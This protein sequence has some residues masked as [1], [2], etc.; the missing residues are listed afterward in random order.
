L[1]RQHATS[2]GGWGKIPLKTCGQKSFR[3]LPAL[4]ADMAAGRRED[5]F[6]HLGDRRHRL[7]SRA[8]LCEAQA[9]V[10]HAECQTITAVYDEV[11]RVG[12]G[13]GWGKLLVVDTQHHPFLCLAI[14]KV[15]VSSKRNGIWA[16]KPHLL[17]RL[18][19]PGR[20]VLSKTRHGWIR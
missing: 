7:A 19:E 15:D 14:A 10:D 8:W 3:K 18:A 4:L 9:T 13:Q 20:Q 2:A 12:D 1:I 16:L 5:L 17:E 11:G 6:S